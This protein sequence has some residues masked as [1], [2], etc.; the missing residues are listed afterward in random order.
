[1]ADAAGPAL[2]VLQAEPTDVSVD[3]ALTDDGPEKLTLA[4][5]LIEAGVPAVMVLPALT[6]EQ[7]HM[8]WGQLDAFRSG[9]ATPDRL[10]G[11]WVALRAQLRPHVAAG[12]LDDLVLITNGGT[13]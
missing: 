12:V 4:S 3:G 2:I 11:Y 7:A 10:A 1:L 6:L 9:A 13:A 5:D 8:V